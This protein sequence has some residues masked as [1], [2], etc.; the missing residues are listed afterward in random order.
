MLI[1]LQSCTPTA[2]PIEYGSDMCAFCKMTIV[3]QKYAAEI[4]TDKGRAYMFDAIECMVDYRRKN[5]DQTAAMYLVNTYTEPGV[6]K[7]AEESHYLISQQ[8]PSPMG[9]Y[10]TA[11]ADKSALEEVRAEKGGEI[12]DWKAL[13]ERRAER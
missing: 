12:Y 10:L 5:Q 13:N 11:F 8:L 4:V 3:D 7:N 9:A 6:L 2:K 1:V